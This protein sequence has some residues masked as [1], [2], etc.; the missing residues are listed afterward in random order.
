MNNIVLRKGLVTGIKKIE[1][2]TT[3]STRYSKDTKSNS[4]NSLPSQGMPKARKRLDIV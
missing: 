3:R 1:I 2:S 4:K